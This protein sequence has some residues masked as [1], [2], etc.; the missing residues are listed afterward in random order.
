ME[1][2]QIASYFLVRIFWLFNRSDLIL[3][4]GNQVKLIR[5]V[6][7]LPFFRQ[8]RHLLWLP[9]CFPVYTNR[10]LKGVYSKKERICS[11]GKLSFSFRID[12]FPEGS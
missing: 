8:G 10:L 4:L 1:I 9:V 2:W 3:V 6:D 7:C 5:V 11:K 12:F